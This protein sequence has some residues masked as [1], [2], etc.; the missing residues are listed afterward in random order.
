MDIT[1][2]KRKTSM[3]LFCIEEALGKYIFDNEHAVTASHHNMKDINIQD[4][5]ERAY[6]DDI[7]QLVLKA[8]IG[9]PSESSV[10]RLYKLSHDLCLFEVRNAIAHPNRPFLDVYWYRV[11]ALAADPAFEALGIKEPK[12][13]LYS[14]EQGTISEPP[15]GWDKKYLWNI[16]NNLPHKFE[17]DITGLIGRNRDLDELKKKLSSQRV[18]TA[19]IVAPGGF[20]KTALALDLLKQLVSSS[21]TTNWLDAVTYVTLKTKTWLDDKFVDLQAVDEIEKVEQNIAEQLGI[22]FDEY[23]DNL[24][25][26]IESFGDKRILIC[27]DNLETIIRDNDDE[28]Q[29]FIDKL[30]REWKVIV[31]SRVTITNA[32]I[33]S[34][35]E[36]NE[37][38][39]IHLARMYN[40]NKGGDELP[41]DKYT[42]IANQCYFNPLAIKMTLDLYLT[43]NQLPESIGKAKSNIANFSFSNLI[44][45]LS[46]NALKILELV[47]SKPDCNRKL[48]CEMLGV[49]TD[50]AAEAINELSRT[51]LLNRTP[52]K[53]KESYEING[54]IK[55]LLIINPKCIAIRE[56]IQAKLIQQQNVL[57]QIDIDQRASNFPCWH[58][59]F[60]PN[61]IESGLKIIM[62]D[63]VKFRFAKNANKG[64]LS[65]LY[66]SFSQN[67]EH[68][69]DSYLFLRSY[70]KV[71]EVLQLYSQAEKLYLKSIALTDDMTTKYMIARYYFETS[72]FDKSIEMYDNLVSQ[73]RAVKTEDDI[74]P[75][76][77]SIYQGYF[78]SHLYIG[79]YDF[80]L[81]YTK[82]WKDE[83]EFSSLFGTY[84]ASAYKRKIEATN[85]NDTAQI[86]S[87]FNSAT[88][89]LD[90]IYRNDGYSLASATQGFK[91]IEELVYF[92]KYEQNCRYDKISCLQFLEF[93][94]KHLVDI[95]DTSRNKSSEDI[96]LIARELSNISVPNNPFA[97]KN[98]WQSYSSPNYK[99][100]INRNDVNPEYTLVK[101]HR[102]A[103]NK[104]G[105]RTNFLFSR[106]DKDEEYFVHFDSLENCDWHDWL[107]LSSNE[108]LAV[109]DATRV[110]GRNALNV[111]SCYLVE[112]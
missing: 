69:S 38:N 112:S 24:E 50:Y 8:T 95:V 7:F 20:G 28:F 74:I 88:K 46:E 33:Y 89:I 77:D 45:S 23:I 111:L 43:G 40:R 31:T 91:V 56:H 107:K 110:Q 63:F 72:K 51:S 78:L 68:Y 19:A 13:T 1:I 96:K 48:I 10:K 87:I 39:A 27:I 102:F 5:I 73:I 14:A 26:A 54:S 34:L 41:Q 35:Q 61:D 11:A 71:C 82:K 18:H 53:D 58:I 6:L 93:C 36:L 9:T 83:E 2:T 32:Y 57:H 94:D 108:Q 109:K 60:L 37:R 3:L 90:D 70:A 64:K 42:Q 76:Y 29:S 22:I 55:D 49:S 86:V 66:A 79:H 103:E 99:N 92:Y 104:V 25:Q 85:K 65:E 97:C 62:A 80:V 81:E 106:D 101:I 12:S 84:R 4:A 105:N 67:E 16:P 75:F 47:F 98:Y 52:N 21:E 30:P 59:Q 100:A 15:E 17:S 44:D